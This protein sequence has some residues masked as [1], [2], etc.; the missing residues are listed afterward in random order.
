M[1]ASSKSKRP[2]ACTTPATTR[3]S[4]SRVQAVLDANQTDVIHDLLAHLAQQMIDLNKQKQGEM[5]RFLR[6]LED[7]TEDRPEQRW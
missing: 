7:R 5:R 6:W 2:S 4:L 1:S 3:N